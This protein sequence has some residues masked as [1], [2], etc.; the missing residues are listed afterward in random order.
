[1][2]LPLVP[3]T[4]NVLLAFRLGLVAAFVPVGID[5]CNLAFTSYLA[6]FEPG[7]IGVLSKP[8]VGSSDTCLPTIMIIN[9]VIFNSFDE[10]SETSEIGCQQ[11]SCPE[12]PVPDL[13]HD[14]YKPIFGTVFFL[15]LHS[16]HNIAFQ[17]AS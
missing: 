12:C 6:L 11:E 4:G 5:K 8:M 1:M 7:V 9:E 14:S 17:D 2:T 15:T 13:H 3:V 10:F 16:G